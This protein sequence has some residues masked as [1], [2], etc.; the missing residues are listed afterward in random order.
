MY[1]MYPNPANTSFVQQRLTI[2]LELELNLFPNNYL[3][4]KV[5]VF[6]CEDTAGAM[7]GETLPSASAA[8]HYRNAKAVSSLLLN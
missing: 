4:L 6:P 7:W 2:L 3:Y 1:E 8:S 5:Y